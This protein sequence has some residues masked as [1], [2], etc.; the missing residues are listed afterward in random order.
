MSKFIRLILI[1][2]HARNIKKNIVFRMGS[3]DSFDSIDSFVL[4]V[5]THITKTEYISKHNTPMSRMKLQ[6]EPDF[7]VHVKIYQVNSY[8]RTC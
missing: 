6:I 8:S 3:T 2:E 1:Q 4:T 5:Y 7:L